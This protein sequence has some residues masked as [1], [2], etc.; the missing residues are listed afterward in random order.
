M[1]SPHTYYIH[2]HAHTYHAHTTHKKHTHT[3]AQ[4]K[5]YV[6]TQVGSGMAHMYEEAYLKA[7]KV[8]DAAAEAERAAERAAELAQGDG[9]VSGGSAP[10]PA[11]AEGKGAAG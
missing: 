10:V 7:A 1:Q 5:T 3:H 9:G 6:H 2:T 8:V 4:A 11:V